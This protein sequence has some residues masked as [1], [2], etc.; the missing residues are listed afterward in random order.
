M[1]DDQTMGD[2]NLEEQC[3]LLSE[4]NKKLSIDIASLQLS[5]RSLVNQNRDEKKKVMDCRLQISDLESRLKTLESTKT[6]LADC[7]TQSERLRASLDAT[8]S[9]LASTERRATEAESLIRVK[10]SIIEKQRNFSKE[11]EGQVKTLSEETEAL[12]SK[13]GN[14]EM[15]LK[16]ALDRAEECDNLREL[17]A[18]KTKLLDD[19]SKSSDGIGESGLAAANEFFKAQEAKMTEQINELKH[20]RSELENSL[21]SLASEKELLEEKNLQKETELNELK[22]KCSSLEAKARKGGHGER[23]K[24]DATNARLIG[25]SLPPWIM[26]EKK[27]DPSDLEKLANADPATLRSRVLELESQVHELN[28]LLTYR[29]DVILRIHEEISKKASRLEAAEVERSSLSAQVSILK[30]ELACLRDDAPRRRGGYPPEIEIEIERLRGKRD[31]E[32]QR[33]K[34]AETEMDELDQE[35]NELKAKIKSLEEQLAN[36]PP[37]KPPAPQGDPTDKSRIAELQAALSQLRMDNEAKR[38]ELFDL[39]S[40]FDEKSAQVDKLA[41][42][43]KTKERAVAELSTELSSKISQLEYA[44]KELESVRCRV[45]RGGSETERWQTDINSV[46]TTNRFLSAQANELRLKLAG[47]EKRVENLQKQLM[48]KLQDSEYAAN[49]EQAPVDNHPLTCPA[50]GEEMRN[51]VSFADNNHDASQLKDLKSKEKQCKALEQRLI[52]ATDKGVDLAKRVSELEDLVS[53]LKSQLSKVNKDLADASNS[54]ERLKII[55]VKHSDL[56]ELYANLQTE[57]ENLRDSEE[58][59]SKASSA[60][61]DKRVAEADGRIKQLLQ[62][63]SREQKASSSFS[64][65]CSSLTAQISSLETKLEETRSK[66]DD[67]KSENR[68]ADIGQIAVTISPPAKRA[69]RTRNSAAAQNVSSECAMCAELK[70]QLQSVESDLVEANHLRSSSV[71]E[72]NELREQLAKAGIESCNLRNEINSLQSD[73][74]NSSDKLLTIRCAIMKFIGDVD[75][76]QCICSGDTSSVDQL[77]LASTASAQ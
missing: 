30:R 62:D 16:E 10:D 40:R 31:R 54:I 77:R 37:P 1:A 69:R 24:N 9:K 38:S 53:S 35:N 52:E 50:C 73:L 22:E 74:A 60:F 49:S 59:N 75:S 15:N 46:R 68:R 17:L 55:E 42:E 67:S 26:E 34:R 18:A 57:M 8:E 61:V 44:N 63:L 33:R 28:Q 19:L 12:K 7:Q 25:P 29:E 48:S 13:C 76:G 72:L 3:R 41:A 11:L 39:R 20:T 71:S 56:Q 6:E 4:E 27:T 32:Y 2:V 14:L 23:S 36:I 5:N 45:V 21:A 51:G 65:R 43:V 58:R 70:L 64:E 47:S 66:L